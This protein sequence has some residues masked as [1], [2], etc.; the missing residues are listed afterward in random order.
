[1]NSSH[2]PNA[3]S[4]CRK[5]ICMLFL[6]ATSYSGFSQNRSDSNFKKNIP[7]DANHSEKTLDE[8]NFQREEILF[9]TVPIIAIRYIKKNIIDPLGQLF[10]CPDGAEIKQ[11]NN[12]VCAGQKIKFLV[13]NVDN[14]D[15]VSWSVTGAGSD[16]SDIT[17][18]DVAQIRAN[19]IN[20]VPSQN[21]MMT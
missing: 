4:A 13:N 9:P 6:L 18:V 15:E 21:A 1:M 7:Q 5:S 2:K 12:T 16:I 19:I 17:G 8:T 20:N 3:L 11:D 10:E 14:F